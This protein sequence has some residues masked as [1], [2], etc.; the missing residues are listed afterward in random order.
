MQRAP[1]APHTL[2]AARN[3]DAGPSPP[4]KLLARRVSE[5]DGFLEDLFSTQIPDANDLLSSI[6]VR[7][8]N[9]GMGR[10]S[11]RDG[12]FDAGIRPRESGQMGA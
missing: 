7:P 12:D 11:R 8:T 3:H 2:L 5:Q 1:N 9:D 4:P 6:D 10:R